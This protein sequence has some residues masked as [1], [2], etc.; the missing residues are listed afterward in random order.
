VKER[1]EVCPPPAERVPEAT[2]LLTVCFTCRLLSA[3][4][5]TATARREE[6]STRKPCLECVPCSI[7]FRRVPGCS[8][9]A[10]PVASSETRLRSSSTNARLPRSALFQVLV[11]RDLGRG[12]DEDEEDEADEDLE[13]DGGARGRGGARSGA[14]AGSGEEEEEYE[15]E[16]ED[17]PQG[18]SQYDLL[19][20]RK[21]SAGRYVLSIYAVGCA[22]S[23]VS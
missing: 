15:E 13:E 14:A 3:L 21:R 10:T 18:P 20:S 5:T 22:L 6:S 16:L 7:I 19:A 23:S 9:D 8:E 12:E 11:A 2:E 1:K 4:T 17:E